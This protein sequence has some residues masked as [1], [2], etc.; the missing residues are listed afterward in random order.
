LELENAISIFYQGNEE[1]ASDLKEA[2][3]TNWT[4]N[5]HDTFEV[6]V[7]V[8]ESL[9]LCVDSVHDDEDLRWNDQDTHDALEISEALA[10]FEFVAAL[11]VLKNTMSF[12]SQQP[13]ARTC[14]GLR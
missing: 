12:L 6:A 10:D 14:K 8:V 7:N 1:K 13:S 5:R 3:H 9:L 11:V 4:C 2:C